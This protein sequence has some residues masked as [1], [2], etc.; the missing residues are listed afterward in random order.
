[1]APIDIVAI[2]QRARALRAEEMRRQARL[3]AKQARL[4]RRLLRRSLHALL[5]ALSEALRPLFS[6]NPRAGG[7][8][9][10]PPD[11]FAHASHAAQ[12]LFAWH[13]QRH[14]LP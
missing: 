14:H 5:T 11:N 6:W 8:R 12:G 9:A 4:Y 7:N 13:P 3:F 10:A 1:M 2:E